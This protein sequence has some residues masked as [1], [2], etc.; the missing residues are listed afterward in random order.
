MTHLL[1]RVL[2]GQTLGA[3]AVRRFGSNGPMYSSSSSP[4]SSTSKQST[5]RAATSAVEAVGRRIGADCVSSVDV[6]RGDPSC[7]M[8]SVSFSDNVLTVHWAQGDEDMSFDPTWLRLAAEDCFHSTTQRLINP[9]DLVHFPSELATVL[10][11]KETNR[12]VLSFRGENNPVHVSGE[13]L[14]QHGH[15][16]KRSDRAVF[17]AKKSNATTKE[18]CVVLSYPALCESEAKVHQLMKGLCEDGV[19]VVTGVPDSDHMVGTVAELMSPPID[20]LY[21]KFFNVRSEPNPI[22]IA[23][24]GEKLR[25]HMDLAYYDSPP[26]IQMLHC[27]KFSD[28][29]EGGESTFL[30]AHAA[31]E[32][33]RERYPE[34]FATLT[35]IPAKFQ[36]DHLERETPA[37]FFFERPHIITSSDGEEILSVFWSPPFE[38]MVNADVADI[39]PYY[40]AYRA[41]ADIID[42][43]E[44][45]EKHG[46]RFRLDQGE[47]VIFNNRRFLHGRTAFSLNGGERHL[48]GCYIS[49]DGFMNQFR[50]IDLLHGEVGYAP[51]KMGWGDEC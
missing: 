26:G 43:E 1:R 10:H 16:T 40:E 28:S 12:L 29:V 42:A 23:Y 31:A 45:S 48:E 20:T 17:N 2:P 14:K 11:E 22:N 9:Q 15:R 21:G 46:K 44:T 35:K 34:H 33:L 47:L 18:S 50:K 4:S 41:F 5:R 6:Y 30:D 25:Y 24:T 27:R 19:A 38:G 13:F 39:V 32:I 8:Q 7:C 3:L 49:L 37:Q 36:K 51:P